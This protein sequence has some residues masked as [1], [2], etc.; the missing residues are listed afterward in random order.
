M[1]EKIEQLRD[2]FLRTTSNGTFVERQT[3]PRGV[4]HSEAEVDADLLDAVGAMRER[5]GFRT[6]LSE[7]A[8]VRL[9]RR[10]YAG[11]TDAELAADLG[12]SEEVVR[13]A[14]IHLHLFRESDTE[15]SFD[16]DAFRRAVAPTTTDAT[17]AARFDVGVSTVR[18]YRRLVEALREAR[19][20]SHRDAAEFETILSESGAPIVLRSD[21]FSDVLS[22]TD[23]GESVSTAT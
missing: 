2:I 20:V 5:Y 6:S 14:R 18:E 15:A 4:L 16:F 13:R 12:C 19:R 1:D 10:F 22:A 8:L 17:L 21:P 9:I 11:D 3:T 7:R 23:E